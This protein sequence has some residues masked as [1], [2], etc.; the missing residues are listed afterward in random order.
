MLEALAHEGEMQLAEVI[1]V[2]DQF[3]LFRIKNLEN[4]IFAQ[5]VGHQT[6]QWSRKELYAGSSTS[7]SRTVE[8][9]G[10]ST[11]RVSQ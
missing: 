7:I 9:G 10:L 2:V 6:C 8:A 1:I 3:R 5:G 4:E 11:H